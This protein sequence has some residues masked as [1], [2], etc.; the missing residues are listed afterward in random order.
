MGRPELTVVPFWLQPPGASPD[1]TNALNRRLLERINASR[2]VFM[3]STLV[4]GR[5]VIRP[6]IVVHR[7]HRDRID[8]AIDVTRKAVADL[9]GS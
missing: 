3:S 2:R 9:T 1:E 4:R 6:C 5:F 7:T 8:E